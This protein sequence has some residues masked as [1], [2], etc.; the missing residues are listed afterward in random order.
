AG[1][2]VIRDARAIGLDEKVAVRRPRQA[3]VQDGM[4]ELAR[5]LAIELLAR[6]DGLGQLGPANAG[7]LGLLELV[8]GAGIDRATELALVQGTGETVQGAVALL[9][10]EL[11]RLQQ[12]LAQPFDRAALLEEVHGSFLAALVRVAVQDLLIEGLD[13]LGPVFLAVEDE[14]ER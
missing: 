9:L 3:A 1:N 13:L 14:V 11:V 4:E 8:L 7:L 5:P 12:E 10:E 2:R 6:H